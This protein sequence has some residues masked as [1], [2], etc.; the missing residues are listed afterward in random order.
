MGDIRHLINGNAPAG[1]SRIDAVNADSVNSIVERIAGVNPSKL[2]QQV[3]GERI[4]E[5]PADGGSFGGPPVS[6]T[7]LQYT[8]AQQN[9]YG[10]DPYAQQQPPPQGGDPQAMAR[11]QQLYERMQMLE[12]KVAYYESG[13]TVVGYDPDRGQGNDNEAWAPK[14]KPSK[15]NKKDP[16]DGEPDDAADTSAEEARMFSDP[17]AELGLS[18]TECLGLSGVLEGVEP[19]QRP[20]SQAPAPPLSEGYEPEELTEEDRD[21][22]WE[23]FLQ[24]RGISLEHLDALVD[25]ALARDDE[26]TM[27]MVLALEDQFHELLGGLGQ[28]VGGAAS[29]LDTAGRKVGQAA[30][31]GVKKVAKTAATAPL[32]AVGLVKPKLPK[33]QTP[34]P[35]PQQ[36][37]AAPAKPPT[38]APTA[39]AQQSTV[40]PATEPTPK[41]KPQLSARKESVESFEF[42]ADAGIDGSPAN[43]PWERILKAYRVRQTPTPSDKSTGTDTTELRGF[44]SQNQV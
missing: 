22:L 12:K 32:K 23:I 21:E 28:A 20:Q 37:V 5:G 39:G 42:E 24:E 15:K 3:T 11:M 10:A 36:P 43:I 29:A 35:Q 41:M 26:D 30:V 9:S 44:G 7:P 2:A 19:R 14:M 34:A 6:G 18:M 38:A 31:S 40:K 13:N 8:Q 4:Q 33:P 25:D 27:E 16:V 17:L 1:S